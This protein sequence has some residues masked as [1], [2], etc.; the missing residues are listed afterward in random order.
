MGNLLTVVQA[1]SELG[2]STQR[3]RALIAAKRLRAEKVGTWVITRSALDL[4][5]V[6]KP[7]RPRKGTGVKNHSHLPVYHR[8]QRQDWATPVDLFAKLDAEFHFTLDAAASA[9]NAKCQRYFTIAEDGLKQPWG[10]EVVF[11]NPPYGKGQ[12]EWVRKAYDA[13]LAGATVVL[14]LP[15]RPGR[16]DWQQY[17]HPCAEVRYLPGRIKFEGAKHPAP[18]ESAVVI[19]RPPASNER[20]AA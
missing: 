12:G 2:V 15:A 14:L 9:E 4:V 17:V 3:V 18:F 8:S 1:A 5:R 6:R 13:S 10:R 16:R 20:Q 11:V 7:G 19:F